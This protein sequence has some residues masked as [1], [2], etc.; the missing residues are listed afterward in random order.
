VIDKVTACTRNAG[1]VA[2]PFGL[3]GLPRTATPP[4]SSAPQQVLDGRARQLAPWAQVNA[5]AL[6]VPIVA[7]HR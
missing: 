6:L 3:E 2:R 1:A 5:T 7:S 4:P